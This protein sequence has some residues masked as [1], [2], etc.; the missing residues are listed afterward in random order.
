MEKTTITNIEHPLYKDFA[1]LYAS[2][3][4]LCEQRTVNQQQWAF[5]Q[6]DYQLIA[7]CNRGAF[8]GF[9]SIWRMHSCIYVEHFSVQKSLRG[10]GWGS[11]ILQDFQQ[12]NNHCIILEIDPV[13][14]D[15]T[16]ARLRF[17]E[18]C[19]F[20]QNPYHHLHPP[21]REGFKPHPLTIMSYP[22]AL[23]QTLF[24]EFTS[25]LQQMMKHT[26]DAR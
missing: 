7:Y 2:S 14:D 1:D 26:E 21:Y 16:R 23:T 13:C 22:S 25:D 15:V 20:C 18:H 12:Q 8:V 11:R 4:P 19:G 3:F 24:H 9:L 6:S 5:E 10:K 17:Y